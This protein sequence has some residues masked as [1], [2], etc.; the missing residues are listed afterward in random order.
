MNPHTGIDLAAFA[1]L[2]SRFESAPYAKYLD[3]DRWLQINHRRVEAVGLDGGPSRRVL[4]IG[5]GAGYFLHICRLH[6]HD[7][8]GLDMFEPMF[9]ALNELLD[10]PVIRA[11]IGLDG[12]VPDGLGAFDVVTAH[13]I[14]FNGH[15]SDALW[16]PVQ[17]TRFLDSLD[18]GRIYLEL[19]REHDGTLWPPGVRELFE[20]RGAQIDAHR[21]LI[22][23][24]G[25]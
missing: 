5:C 18:A 10:V 20:E 16:G 11:P 13:M 22:D 6:G 24:F 12:S 25:R 19:N 15:C 7:I 4:D 17:W 3:L 8:Q 9:E 23:R 2:A 21:V 14:T 1:A